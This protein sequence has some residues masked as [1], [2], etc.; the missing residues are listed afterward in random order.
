MASGAG[1]AAFPRKEAAY[2][3]CAALFAVVLVITNVIGI[4]LFTVFGQTLT[5]GI[6][7]YPITFFLTDLVSE[8]WGRKR[9]QTMV[10][11]G[12]VMSMVLLV[13]LQIAVALPP[14]P[15][16]TQTVF[17][18]ET[19]EDTQRA[20]GATFANPGVLLFASM[21]AYLVAQTIDVRLYHF[22]WRVTGGGHM[23]IRNNASTS[24]SQLID[25]IIVNSIFLHFG[26]GFGPDNGFTPIVIGQIIVTN[27]VFKLVM[28][29]LDT[30]VIYVGRAA[31]ERFIGIEHDPA[32]TSAP[33]A[34]P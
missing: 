30:P 11:Y 22:W 19:P 23:W 25:T 29:A 27:Y 7:T 17:G 18:F 9:A 6:I 14:S 20:F 26:T 2:A 5:V 21:V 31:A 24:I 3:F 28:A 4:K 1:E 16:W 32:R 12:F 8:I 13:V 34:E 10:I 33:L 15:F